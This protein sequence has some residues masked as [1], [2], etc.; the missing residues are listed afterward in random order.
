MTLPVRAASSQAAFCQRTQNWAQFQT[1]AHDP[2]NL[3]AF[4]NPPGPW[5]TGLCWWHTRFQRLALYLTIYR[6]E[7][8]RPTHPAQVWRLLDTVAFARGVVEIPG[9]ENF[10]EFS[11]AWEETITQYLS[12]WQ[13]FEGLTR[14]TWFRHGALLDRSE[15]PEGLK[16]RMDA[17]YETV[18]V[19]KK[20]AFTMLQ[21]PGISTHAWLVVGMKRTSQGYELSYVDS[22]FSQSV[23]TY[24]Y[25]EGDRHVNDPI[26]G[27]IYGPGVL[28]QLED[29]ELE[30]AISV[31]HAYCRA[32]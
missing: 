28:H 20:L 15:T 13:S 24:E 22:A 21:I 23:G 16:R 11:E 32:R 10:S 7:L 30:R 26:L 18:G 27:L 3:F 5:K 6:P 19:Q 14:A 12:Q 9:Y 31:A 25:R 1:Y 29:A 8:P 17:L 4:G 2:A